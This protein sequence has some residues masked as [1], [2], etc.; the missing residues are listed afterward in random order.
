MKGHVLILEDDES[1]A[2][3]LAREFQDHGYTV[4]CFETI[5]D[6]ASS[7]S[8]D[9]AVIDLRL[10]GGG[11]GLNAIDPI[12]VKSPNCRIV[13]LSGYGSISTAVEAV[14]RG[15]IDYL[16]KPASF[17]EIE[18]A[19]LGKRLSQDPEFRTQSLSEVE[20]EHIDFVLTKN[21]GNISRTA[22][23]LGLHRQSLQRKLKKYT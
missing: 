18:A 2:K 9:F 17:K 15:A 8:F 16:T 20:H 23:E 22:R 10:S 13:I 5:S 19:L 11:F 7:N 14:K 21:D 1:L 12:R 6:F 3:S 4:E